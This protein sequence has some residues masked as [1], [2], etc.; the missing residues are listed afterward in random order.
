MKGS[1]L[2][3]YAKAS[4]GEARSINLYFIFARSWHYLKSS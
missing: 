4:V 2:P 1:K 3:T